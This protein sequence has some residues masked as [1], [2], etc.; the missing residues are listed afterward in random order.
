[1]S[2]YPRGSEWR[3]WDLHI[4]STYSQES[5]AKLSPKE[6]FEAASKNNIAVVS[7]TDHSNVD[8]LDE[9]WDV[10]SHEIDSN[11]KN[12]SDIITFFPGVEL[13]ASTGKRGVHFLAIFPPKTSVKSYQQNV[14]QKFLKESFLAKIGC[15]ESDI[16]GYGGGDYKKGLFST[17][18]N[19]EKTAELVR[20][21]GGVIIVHNGDKERSLEKEI[22]HASANASP[23]E[24][25]NTL[26]NKKEDLMRGCIDICELPNWSPY[27]QKQQQFYLKTFNK[28]S[29][30]FS[31]SH[32]SYKIPC[33]TWIK[34]DPTF[35]GLR[36]VLN[37]PND[38][39]S[40]QNPPAILEHVR[41]NR[42]FYIRSI[43][44]TPKKNE[45]GW[46]NDKVPLNQNLVAVIGNKGTGKSALADIISLLGNTKQFDRF[47]FLD[48]K[49]FRDKK[50]GK[51]AHFQAEMSWLDSE[52]SGPMT[53]EKNPEAGSVERV[54][55]LPQDFINDICTDLSSSQNSQFY[56]ELQGV[57]FSH[58]KEHERLNYNSLAELLEQETEETEKRIKS[59]I[60]NITQM[61]D[62]IVKLQQQLKPE[63]KLELQN[64]LNEKKRFI[65]QILASKPSKPSIKYIRSENNQKQKALLT[66]LQKLKKREVHLNALRDSFAKER[67]LINGKISTARKLSER[68]IW[69][70]EEAQKFRK[71]IFDLS[72]SIGIN[73]DE[74]LQIKIDKVLLEEKAEEFQA[75]L[76]DLN[77]LLGDHETEF[78]LMWELV[79]LQKRIQ[80]YQNDLDKPE[81]EYQNY[82]QRRKKWKR[83]FIEA[84]GQKS[85][86]ERDTLR[87]FQQEL[88]LI[89]EI[90]Q[91][92]EGLTKTREDYTKKIYQLKTELKEKLRHFHKPVQQFI[93]KH[94]I[95]QQEQFPLSFQVSTSEE[96]FS[97]FFFK[98]IN[99]SRNGSFCGAESGRQRLAD[100][101]NQ[102]DFDNQEDVLA[103]L[104]NIMSALQED[105]RSNSTQKMSIE[106]QLKKNMTES[107]FLNNLFSL[108]YLKPRYNLRWDG[109]Q[110]DQLSPGERGQLLLIFYLLIDQNQTPIII[111]QPEENLDNQTVYKVL[112]PCIKEAKEKRQVIL[113]THNPNLAVVCDAEQIIHAQM[114]KKDKNLIKYTTGAI[115]NPSI[116]QKIVDVLEGTEPA[117]TVRKSKYQFG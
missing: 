62:E 4:H 83:Q 23:D 21:L 99:Q 49:K 47:S 71:E 28:P 84:V 105:L 9:A 13:K 116:N 65:E 73:T 61:N 59:R 63:A 25:L 110:V 60:D 82:L 26:G 102:T 86:P 12:F 37:E 44:I 100:I 18:V 89:K 117:F 45:K 50:T 43:S 36:Q 80:Q 67:V 78:S 19:F 3:K 64:K 55:Y 91:H 41:K 31:D 85:A 39:I 81:K 17:A 40:I 107:D 46:F 58:L 5:R 95:A 53:L 109:K 103:F 92:I 52:T 75:D 66:A 114:D 77:K 48:P 96:S 113:V 93:S 2:R 69:I 54:K 108:T 70:K 51:A 97:D 104:D 101:I 14:D 42:P 74:L 8:G 35:E 68:L 57:I 79:P 88:S 16:K 87:R 20:K 106:A 72:D 90:P 10:W 30:V 29:V 7:I 24:L 98:Y 111:D 33:P 15:S 76:K 115:E 56:R 6:I 94:P 112:V 34:A 1:M 32:K 38:R 27:N 22:A 11:G